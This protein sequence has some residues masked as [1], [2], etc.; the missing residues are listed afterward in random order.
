M[1]IREPGTRV[2]RQTDKPELLCTRTDGCLDR[3]AVGVSGQTEILIYGHMAMRV[4]RQRDRRT[5]R[6]T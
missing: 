6:H 3:Q 2:A 5:Y 1:I 4:A